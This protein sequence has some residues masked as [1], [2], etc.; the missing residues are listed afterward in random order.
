MKVLENDCE[1][2][3]EKDKI[4]KKINNG[5]PIAKSAGWSSIK[6]DAIRH[7]V[8]FCKRVQVVVVPIIHY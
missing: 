6:I 3:I 8:R 1:G 4:T 7:E 5:F 2:M